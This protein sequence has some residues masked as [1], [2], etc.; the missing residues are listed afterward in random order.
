MAF[1]PRHYRLPLLRWRREGRC[2]SPWADPKEARPG[3]N[4]GAFFLFR[5]L[6]RYRN[7][8]YSPSALQK[9]GHISE[10]PRLKRRSEFREDARKARYAGLFFVL[11]PFNCRR[12][13]RRYIKKHSIHFE[14]RHDSMCYAVEHRVWQ[15][16]EICRHCIS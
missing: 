3:R 11:F 16:H 13:L 6:T 15:Q 7:I 12:G 2:L 10:I 9:T 14:Q 5:A 1:P 8:A 4:R